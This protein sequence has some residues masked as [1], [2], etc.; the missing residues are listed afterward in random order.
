MSPRNS[1]LDIVTVPIVKFLSGNVAVSQPNI[2]PTNGTRARNKN[3][4]MYCLNLLLKVATLFPRLLLRYAI[5]RPPSIYI[6]VFL[7]KICISKNM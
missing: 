3:A 6:Y 5:T 4:S 2:P 1:E 7:V